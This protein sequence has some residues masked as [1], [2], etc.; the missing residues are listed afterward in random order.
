M[1][2]SSSESCISNLELKIQSNYTEDDLIDF[3]KNNPHLGDEVDY[4][5]R[6][7]LHISCAYS[8]YMLAEYLVQLEVNIDLRD[9]NGQTALHL[10]D[11]VKIVRLLCFHGANV[12]V[13]DS[14][15]Q[16]PLHTYVQRKLCNC[17][18]FMLS[19]DVDPSL[20]YS[21][22]PVTLELVVHNSC[23]HAAAYCQ[24]F[25]LLSILISEAKQLSDINAKNQSTKTVLHMV[26]SAEDGTSVQQKC[27]MLLLDK[28]ADPNATSKDG[29]TPLH[30]V[31]ANRLN[32]PLPYHCYLFSPLFF[33][34]SFSNY[35]IDNFV[36]WRVSSKD[37]T[38]L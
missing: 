37:K 34:I 14:S 3:A 27:I 7:A 8:I 24:D 19:F 2:T 12:H 35:Y 13:L 17:I 15:A 4:L 22:D 11:D 1:T 10:C 9:S 36:Y 38:S 31:C 23:M 5:G 28:G 26:A 16:T 21:V 29:A 32:P 6:S 20:S 30:L 33:N 18:K 25:E